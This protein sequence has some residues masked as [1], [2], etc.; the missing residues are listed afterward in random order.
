MEKTKILVVDDSPFQRV[1]LKDALTEH[2]FEVIGEAGSLEEVI[3]EVKK[4]KP[5]VV[6]MDMTIPGTDGFECTREIHKIDRT[7]K[8]I[9]VSAMMDD[10]LIIQ[11]NRANISQYIQKPFDSEELAEAVRTVISE[12]DLFLELESSYRD[13]FKQSVIDLFSKLIKKE[14][15]IKHEENVSGEICSNGVAVVMGVTGKHSGRLIFDMS[16][17]TA[18]SLS[19]VLLKR[20]PKDDKEILNV[21]A[22][23]TNMFSGNACSKINKSNKAFGLRVVPPMVLNGQLIQIASGNLQTEYSV[24]FESEFGD[25]KIH[26]GFGRGEVKWM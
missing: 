17:E 7:I 2:G 26:I 12:K 16:F 19:E 15:K 21:I 13:V 5:D 14:I 20:E 10:E 24:V 25:I 11:A 4:S 6:T 1:L 3:E 8:V 18:K 9:I 23:I 22:E